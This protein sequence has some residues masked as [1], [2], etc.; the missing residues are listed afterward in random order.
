MEYYVLLG[1]SYYVYQ[2]FGLIA[3]ILFW[4]LM[5]TFQLAVLDYMWEHD[6]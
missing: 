3:F 4:V 5:V 1:Y 2:E 6:D